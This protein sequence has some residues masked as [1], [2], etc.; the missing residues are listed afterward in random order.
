[1]EQVQRYERA[2]TWLERSAVY[3]DDAKAI[4]HAELAALGE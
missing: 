3:G 4:V 1:V 2:F